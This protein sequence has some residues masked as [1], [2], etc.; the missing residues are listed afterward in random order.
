MTQLSPE[1][2]HRRGTYLGIV[3]PMVGV[4]LLMA[5]MIGLTIAL[6]NPVQFSIVADLLAILF[7]LV[8]YVI[9]CLIPTIIL[10][11]G[12]LGLWA[13][14][15]NIARP[16]RRGRVA[17]VDIMAKGTGYIPQAGKPFIAIQ[18]RLTYWEHLLSGRRARVSPE[19]ETKS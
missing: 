15:G 7:I 6:L 8:P 11:A 1:Q 19:E 12:A 18:T 13:M 3:L 16:L 2:R 5:L 17:L 10:M 9:M 4:L 14:H